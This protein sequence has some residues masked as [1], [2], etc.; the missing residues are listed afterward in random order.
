MLE[1]ADR[2]ERHEEYSN[3]DAARRIGGH[4]WDRGDV[5]LIRSRPELASGLNFASRIRSDSST[6]ERLLDEVS[7][8][9]TA[10]GVVPHVRVS[11][12]SRP[13]DLA[14]RL[15]SRGFVMTEAET[16]MALVGPDRERPTNPRVHVEQI[17]PGDIDCW[18]R[19]QDIGFGGRGE[20]PSLVFE[21]A[22]ASA[23]SPGTHLYLARLDGEP[24]CSGTL[25]F[26]EGVYGIYGV[27]SLPNR[28]G[29]GAATALIRNMI[30][31]ARAG[32]DLP[33]CLQAR[34]GSATQC[35]YERLGFRMVYNR[36][37]WTL[38]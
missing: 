38:K 11:P 10:R 34:T 9:L 21:M 29:Q 16:Q 6:I 36:T 33:I 14:D 24:I 20:P 26:W 31:N 37:G 19:I 30:L 7:E 18:V 13:G 32:G 5:L 35:W 3:A 2:L 8:W 4:V 15:R 27:A 28:R 1:L 23:A 22:R 17:A 25:T 12:L